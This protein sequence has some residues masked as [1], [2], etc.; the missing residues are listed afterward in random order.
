MNI[1]N[2]FLF[3][4]TYKITQSLLHAQKYIIFSPIN[5]YSPDKNLKNITKYLFETIS[6]AQSGVSR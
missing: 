6:Q 2:G 5:I 3:I 1:E 4:H